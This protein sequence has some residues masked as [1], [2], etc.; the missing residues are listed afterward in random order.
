[1]NIKR[2]ILFYLQKTYKD[3]D[4]NQECLIRMRATWDKNRFQAN[5]GYSISP[6]KWEKTSQRVKANTANSK[7]QSA[8]NINKEIQR[9]EDIAEDVFK[10][11]E[12][13]EVIPTVE[14][15]RE[16]FRVADK[17]DRGVEDEV[18]EITYYI[19]LF[20]SEIGKENSWTDATYNKFRA[21]IKHLKKFRP[22]MKLT[23]MTAKTFSEYADY[24][25]EVVD[26]KN[27]TI[28]KNVKFMKWFLRWATEKGHLKSNDW[29]NF[30]PK[31]KK[32]ENKVIYLEWDELMS[33]YE[34]KFP[35]EKKYLDRVR[36]LFCFCCFTSLRYSDAVALNRANIDIKN[37]SIYVVTKKTD[38]RLTIDLNK[39]STTIL[40]KYQGEDFPENKALPGISNQ[41]ANEYIK[42]AC[43]VVGINAP[44]EIEYYKGAVRLKETHPK[45]ELIGTHSGRRTFICNALIMGIPPSTVLQW[46]GHSD[47]K[48]MQPYISVADKAR[49]SA[50][51][52]F[53]EK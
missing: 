7:K 30:E 45:Y 50:M 32:L 35:E 4:A 23:D 53:D 39:Y 33:L 28:I 17:R 9:I 26:M 42:E 20:M 24:L 25:L 41:R 18:K 11:F 13:N 48:A 51:D 31:F 38:N 46:T 47:Y 27:T 44:V 6:E 40:E 37:K 8:Y 12:V 49:R 16:A 43:S 2:R 14:E 21:I 1:M 3:G 29:E 19:N 22:K 36:D 34:Y 52:K 15:Y 5:V 10:A